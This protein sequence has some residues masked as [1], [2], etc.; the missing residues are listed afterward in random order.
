M[1]DWEK[2][3]R[4]KLDKELIDGC[5]DTSTNEFIYK[6]GKGGAIDFYVALQKQI[7][8]MLKKYE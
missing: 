7:K 8:E 5:Y 3:L 6:T 2:E 1:E 4:E